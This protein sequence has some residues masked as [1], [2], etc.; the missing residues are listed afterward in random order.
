MEVG[1]NTKFPLPSPPMAGPLQRWGDAEA[2]LAQIDTMKKAILARAFRG[3]LGTNDPEEWAGE[4]VKTR[5]RK[6]GEQVMKPK[7]LI[8]VYQGALALDTLGLEVGKE[9]KILKKHEIRNL[10]LFCDIVAAAGC[11]ISDFDGYFVGYSINQIGKEFDLLRF[12]DDKLLNIEI[13]SELKVA[14]KLSKILN[15]MKRN[16][17]YLQFLNRPLRIYT[18]VENDGFYMYDHAADTVVQV[19]GQAV[20]EQMRQHTVNYSI[21]P[22]REFVPSNYLISPFNST[23]KFIDGVYF[24]TTAQERIKEEI[25]SELSASPFMCFSVSANAGTGKTLLLYDIAKSM[26]KS[27]LNITIIHCG[28]LNDGHF[29]LIETYKWDIHAVKEVKPTGIES[30]LNGCSMLFV[31]EA[32]RIRRNQLDLIVRTAL[33]K[34]VPIIFSYDVK[35]YLRDNEGRDIGEYLRAEFPSIRVSTKKLTTKIRTNKEMA[36]FITNL[37][38]IGKSQDHLNYNCVTVEYMPDLETLKSYISFLKTN[39][40]VPLTYTTSSREADPYDTLSEI[41]GKNAHNV[42]GQEF[43]KVVFVMDQNFKYNDAHKLAARKGY[44]SPDGMLYQ[45]VTR[46]VN[47]LKI[48]VLDNPE[49]YLKLLE[50]KSLG[51]ASE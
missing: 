33:Q 5:Q 2:V 42:I 11:D 28:I 44:Y 19:D 47:E 4:M 27:G 13:K 21:D 50:I 34:C 20:A 7:N 41:D 38:H 3:E 8:S 45:I 37:F 23:D 24:L 30:I 49:L 29:K 36:S 10:R 35:Q 15:Q 51:T 14:N 26:M 48:I 12:G 25:F 31:D 18:Y 32:Q 1:E 46:V 9:Y 17:H 22:D 43:S 16:Y 40:W 39:G 6:I